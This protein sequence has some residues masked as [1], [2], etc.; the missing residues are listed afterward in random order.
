MGE[1][2]GDRAR[3]PEITERDFHSWYSREVGQS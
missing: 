2:I 3:A 1:A